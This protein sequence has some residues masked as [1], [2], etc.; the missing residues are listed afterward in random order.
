MEVKKTVIKSSDEYSFE[1]FLSKV[2]EEFRKGE[3]GV[4]AA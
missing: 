4:W 2:I 3:F 1:P